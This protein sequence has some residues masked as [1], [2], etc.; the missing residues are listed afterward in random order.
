[1]KLV[2]KSLSIE[3][4]LTMS[5][6]RNISD[7]LT[8]QDVELANAMVDLKGDQGKLTDFIAS[9]KAQ[10]YNS[11]TKE[12][13][14]NYAKVHGDLVR[15]GDTIK[16]ITYYHVRNKDLD[17]TQEAIYKK[18]KTDADSA[19]FDSQVAKRQF[20]IN[21]WTVGNKQD[22]LFIM[23]LIFISLTF[24]APL[25]YLV[26]IELLPLMV[27]YG[28]VCL[29]LIALI[30]TF[31]IRYQYTDKT[32]D[33]RFWNRRRFANMGGPP[34]IPTCEAIQGLPTDVI[35]KVGSNITNLGEQVQEIGQRTEAAR[36]AAASAY[37]AP[38][39]A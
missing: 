16:N 11:V 21:E 28:I 19:T 34:T 39:T 13:S 38:L 22:T 9:R 29:I 14:D 4:H 8:L 7:V 23:Q 26:R 37:T 18:S 12:H 36:A 27:F 25:L 3:A 35:R 24:I 1:M 17:L 33:L 31:M 20:E 6:E 2:F 15:A 5:L 10:V 32:R 30:L